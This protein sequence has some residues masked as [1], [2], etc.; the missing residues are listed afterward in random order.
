MEGFKERKL[1]ARELSDFLVRRLRRRTIF[2]TPQV[3]IGGG[4]QIR[5]DR[6]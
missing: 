2:H 3:D 4:P 1:F 6:A 5:Q